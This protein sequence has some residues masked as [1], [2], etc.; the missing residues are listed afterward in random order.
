VE[1]VRTSPP[2]WKT[3]A[4]QFLRC[5]IDVAGA[6]NGEELLAELRALRMKMEALALEDPTSSAGIC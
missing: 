6:A 1:E 4:E 2:D 5:I 3:E